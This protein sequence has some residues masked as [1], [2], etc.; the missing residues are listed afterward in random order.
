MNS[1]I[2]GAVCYICD[3]CMEHC[4]G[5][6]ILKQMDFNMKNAESFFSRIKQAVFILL[7]TDLYIYI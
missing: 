4:G 3:A 6:Q 5:S 1:H 2:R 7:M